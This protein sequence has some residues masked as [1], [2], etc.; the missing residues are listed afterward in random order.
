MRSGAT[1]RSVARRSGVSLLTVQ[2]WV[3]RAR[4]LDL[5]AVDWVDRSSAP[6]YRPT[7][8]PAALEDEILRI[9]RVLRTESL[10]GDHGA[11]AIRQELLA[12]GGPAPSVRTI[13]RI[14]ARRGALDARRR[15]R[16]PAPP[17]GWYLPAVAARQAELD[18]VDAI[19]GLRLLGGIDIE[20]LTLISLHGG[21]AGAWPSPPLT[22]NL[23]IDALLEHWRAFGLPGYAQFDN[24]MIFAGTHGRPDLGRVGRMCLGL[25][26]VPVFAPPR[27]MGFQASVESF[28][29]RWQ[30]RLW[31][32]FHEPGL[33]G[34]RARSD[35]WIAADRARSAIRIEAAPARLPVPTGWS[36]S[37]PDRPTGRVVYLRRTDEQGEVTLLRQ[38]FHVTPSWPYRLVRAELDL[39]AAVIR[40]FA[41]RRREPADQPLLRETPFSAPWPAPR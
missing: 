35:A 15:E 18:Q 41:L 3:E 24:A 1:M 2:R 27:E 38:R 36:P 10:L 29:G 34:V 28:N 5:D 23:V 4:G 39:D 31:R 40:F 8:T 20:I 37:E 22:T 11:E 30:A 9:R 25:G 6:Q 21:L 26:V 19:E 13:G 33:A 16:R 7:R 17:V 14:L 12:G 32:R